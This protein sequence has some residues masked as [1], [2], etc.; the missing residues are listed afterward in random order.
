MKKLL[1]ITLLLTCWKITTA[2]IDRII[3]QGNGVTTVEYKT[4]Y[5]ITKPSFSASGMA[6]IDGARIEVKRVEPVTPELCNK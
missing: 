1:L 6:V 3:D 2:E 4:I 5:S